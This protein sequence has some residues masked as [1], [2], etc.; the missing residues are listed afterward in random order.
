MEIRSLTLLTTDKCNYNC[1]Y[2]YQKKTSGQDIDPLIAQKAIKYVLNNS[3][4]DLDI[5]FSGGEP[6]LKFYLIDKCVFFVNRK[7]KSFKKN[8][9][10]S[11]I[12]N[13]SM[14]DNDVLSIFD[15]NSFD[16]QYSFDVYL[17]EKREER[18]NFDNLL[19]ILSKLIKLKHISLSTNTVFTPDNAD[20]IF[21]SVEFLL[22]KG[23]N[24]IGIG[25]DQ[26]SYWDN[27]SLDIF[28][29]ELART[30][31]LV[32]KEYLRTGKIVVDYFNLDEPSGINMCGAGGDKLTVSPDGSLWGCPSFYYY[33]WENSFE[34]KENYCYGKVDDL[35]NGDF[36]MKY[37]KIIS[38]YRK[39]RT[40][41]F[42]TENNKCF[43][44]EYLLECRICPAQKYS[45]LPEK[46][47]MFTVPEMVCKMNK[48]IFGINREFR[49]EVKGKNRY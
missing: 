35:D 20:K 13:G 4:F 6:L 24:Q 43:L 33:D 15:E 19:E 8:I 18:K 48:I 1:S 41:N 30:K 47:S 38:N 12:T 9:N 14:I 34:E 32:I 49:R 39:F 3:G 46:R 31:D 44:C 7:D 26:T 2:C 25:I 21:D 11:I 29:E 5:I 28:E 40:D 17:K 42:R 36:E 37:E 45:F 27:E 16:V 10:F 22:K 23:V